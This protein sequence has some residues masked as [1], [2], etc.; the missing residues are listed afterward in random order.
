[1]T[2][3]TKGYPQAPMTVLFPFSFSMPCYIQ[4][5]LFVSLSIFEKNTSTYITY[6]HTLLSNLMES[7]R[8]HEI[9][10]CTLLC[11]IVAFRVSC[12]CVFPFAQKVG[13]YRYWYGLNEFIASLQRI[14]RIFL[15]LWQALEIRHFSVQTVARY[16][17]KISFGSNAM[18]LSWAEL[19]ERE[20]KDPRNTL[21]KRIAISAMLGVYKSLSLHLFALE[22]ATERTSERNVPSSPERCN[23]QSTIPTGF[24]R[25]DEM[26]ER[27]TM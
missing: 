12:P 17:S 10:T 5:V 22:K 20:K 16:K 14:L 26:E 7:C 15:S 18:A 4:S 9:L 8:E 3:N 13:G 11:V 21:G 1:M 6:T 23:F 25:P 19:P 2:S 24:S 27:R